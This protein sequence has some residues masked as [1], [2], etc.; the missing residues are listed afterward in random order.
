VIT[1]WEI[2]RTPSSSDP[3]RHHILID[4]DAGDVRM[5]LMRLGNHCGRPQRVAPPYTYAISLLNADTEVLDRAQ[6]HVAGIIRF[7]E[8]CR[9]IAPPRLAP[10]PVYRPVRQP[11]VQPFTIAQAP[12][13]APMPVEMPPREY[14]PV[15]Q[16]PAPVQEEFAPAPEAVPA[17]EQVQLEP[18]IQEAAAQAPS[19]ESGLAVVEAASPVQPEQPGQVV[20]P[21]TAAPQAEAVPPAQEPEQATVPPAQETAAPAETPVQPPADEPKP[22]VAEAVSPVLPE[23]PAPAVEPPVVQPEPVQAAVP[24]PVPQEPPP[25]PQAAPVAEQPPVAQPPVQPLPAIAPAEPAPVNLPEQPAGGVQL[26]STAIPIP[27][28]ETPPSSPA[29]L[30]EEADATQRGAAA[31]DVSLHDNLS[32]TPLGRSARSKTKRY[33][34]GPEI[35]LIPIFNMDALVPGANRFAHAAAMSVMQNPGTMYNP[36]LLFGPKG[37]GKTH[38]LNAIAYSL[39]GAV[40]QANVMVTDGI[41]LSRVVARLAAEKNMEQL[42]Q[43]VSN[44]VKALLIDDIHLLSVNDANKPYLSRWLN[45]FVQGGKQIVLTSAYPP[46]N[47]AKLESMLDFSLKQ[48]WVVELKVSSATTYRS[49]VKRILDGFNTVLSDEDTM[50]FFGRTQM[51]LNSVLR[52]VT[53]MKTLGR[54]LPPGEAAQYKEFQLLEMVLGV[55]ESLDALPPP[56]DLAAAPAVS[57]PAGKGRCR[58][59]VF[60]PKG[61]KDYGKWLLH[62]L[63]VT[64][65]QRFGIKDCFEVIVEREYDD[66]DLVRSAFRIANTGDDKELQGALIIGPSKSDA[67][68]AAV[69]DFG[70]IAHHMLESMLVR[71]ALVDYIKGP[72]QAA[73]LRALLDLVR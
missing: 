5:I 25:Q 55:E 42:D 16:Q 30:P 33:R 43:L 40:G 46:R 4:G 71:C 47:L 66:A 68:A 17:V 31:A 39:N 69:E 3:D 70:D 56:E 48:G 51:P 38:F 62:R 58:I 27:S 29:S 13:P 37:T 35:P 24:E 45:S 60:Y 18:Q 6:R 41:R 72:S 67:E 19:E 59:G 10:A 7:G 32:Q 15:Y 57:A 52:N 36:L 14:Q 53:R 73:Q 64:A 11:A 23:H 22:F 50:K 63:A 26:S 9:R 44:S 65:E 2:R 34:W 28:L 1:H 54:L 8:R 12:A 20:S 61:A 21:Q 49:V